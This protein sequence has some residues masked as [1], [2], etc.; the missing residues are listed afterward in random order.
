MRP[1]RA[2]TTLEPLHGPRAEDQDAVGALAAQHLLPGEGDDV[3]LGEVEVLGED[4]RGG[5]ADREA[6]AVV[7]DPVARRARARPRWCRSR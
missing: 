6:L 1:R 2:R 4:G 5:V 7:R 3:E